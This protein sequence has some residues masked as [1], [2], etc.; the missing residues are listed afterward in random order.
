ML[1]SSV[2]N[3]SQS[4]DNAS[5]TETSQSLKCGDVDIIEFLMDTLICIFPEPD[6]YCPCH[7]VDEVPCAHCSA[8]TS[9]HWNSSCSHVPHLE[10]ATN[11]HALQ[12][13]EIVMGDQDEDDDVLMH[14]LVNLACFGAQ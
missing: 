14:S 5:Q 4:A 8:C 10:P 13:S 2:S 1:S 3:E 9:C 11:P 6:C 12:T 7:T